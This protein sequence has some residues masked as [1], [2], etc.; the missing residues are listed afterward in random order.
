MPSI[1]ITTKQ[2]Y[3]DLSSWQKYLSQQLDKH[4]ILPCHAVWQF[5]NY[6]EKLHIDDVRALQVQLN[7]T[8]HQQTLIFV[9]TD[10]IQ[11]TDTV[12]N[13][14]LKILE[15]PPEN[16]TFVLVTSTLAP[17]L[18]TIQSRCQLINDTQ[19]LTDADNLFPSLKE[20]DYSHWSTLD[21]SQ[22]N[23]TFA[24]QF[25]TKMKDL[26]KTH[27]DLTQTALSLQAFT[28]YLQTL[29]EKLHADTNLTWQTQT[30]RAL[31]QSIQ[32]LRANVAPKNV[33]YFFALQVAHL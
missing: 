19:S 15:E 17:I 24:N 22:L 3:P 2:Q 10:M 1:I 27:P 31:S 7:V 18:P 32:F 28:F 14:L 25:S 6:P 12:Q 26:K 13:S 11:A 16:V 9:L 23:Q 30:L 5:I 21:A 33:Y 29:T 8:S 20:L 4:H